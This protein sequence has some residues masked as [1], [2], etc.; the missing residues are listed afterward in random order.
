MALALLEKGSRVL[1]WVLGEELG[2]GAPS[3]GSCLGH[4]QREPHP[5]QKPSWLRKLLPSLP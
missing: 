3:L 1:S 2:Q 5:G 4:G